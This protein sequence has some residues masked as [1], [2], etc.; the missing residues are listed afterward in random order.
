L[1]D[2]KSDFL[3]LRILIPKGLKEEQL[4]LRDPLC[5]CP[6]SEPRVGL[7]GAVTEI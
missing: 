1:W 7:S 4:T 3:V 2:S 5:A 6:C